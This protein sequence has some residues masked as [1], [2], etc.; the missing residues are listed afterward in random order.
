MKLKIEALLAYTTMEAIKA[1]TYKT[2]NTTLLVRLFN[3]DP[4]EA[5]QP[6][7]FPDA[8]L[9]FKRYLLTDPTSFNKYSNIR[10][11][12]HDYK[13]GQLTNN[14]KTDLVID[15]LDIEALKELEQ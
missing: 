2:Q 1:S 13:D 15:N 10:P 8:T 3:S 9:A 14:R 12:R 11:S 5:T 6:A 7:L 4:K